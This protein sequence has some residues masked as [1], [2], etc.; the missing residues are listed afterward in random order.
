MNDNVTPKVAWVTP[1]LGVGGQL[2][3]WGPILQAY[4]SEFPNLKIFTAFFAGDIKTL[5][6]PVEL[7][8][9]LNHRYKDGNEKYASG[10]AIVGM[11]LIR[12]LY[13]FN[14][15]LIILNEFSL[16]SLYALIV[17]IIL[18]HPR[19]LVIAEARPRLFGSA[20]LA[21]VRKL[22]RKFIIRNIDA[23]LTNNSDGKDYLINELQAP[24]RKIIASPYL[25]SILEKPGNASTPP[26]CLSGHERK[27][28]VFLFIG[29]LTPRKG[30]HYAISAC[31]ILLSQGIDDFELWIVGDGPMRTQLENQAK[32]AGLDRNIKFFGRQ[33]YDKLYYF[34]KEADVFIFPTICDYRSLAVFEALSVGMP[35]LC[36]TGDGGVVETVKE[37]ENGY[38]FNPEDTDELSKYM[39]ILISDRSLRE[40]FSEQSI[41]MSRHF[42]LETAR[43][44][45]L[46]ATNLALGNF[47]SATTGK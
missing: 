26:Q 34:C 42:Q 40:R 45:L 20:W 10:F 27:Q 39:E 14:P 2:L 8:G 19:I 1:G 23:I 25:V 35:I 33:P 15:D 6:L 36:S 44:S 37:G 12:R 31:E 47:K 13:K 16:L 18:R 28:C 3:Y 43:Q 22:L 21:Y 17:K 9:K 29:Q 24:E 41:K 30:V 7:V 11:G 46:T 32:S 38:S 4:Y 5:P